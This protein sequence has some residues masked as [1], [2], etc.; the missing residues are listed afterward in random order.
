MKDLTLLFIAGGKSS[1]FGGE[2]KM[3]SK[4]GPN[5]ETLFEMSIGQMMN[6][7]HIVQIHVVVNKENKEKIMEE[8]KRVNQKHEI[9]KNITYNIQDVPEFRTKPWGTADAV[10]SAKGHVHTPFLL[11]NSDDLYDS[12]TFQ[13]IGQ[14]C[15][16]SKNY[17]IGFTLGSTLSGNQKA[18]RA[19]ISTNE[20]EKVIELQEKLNIE[21]DYYNKQQLENQYVSVN[22]LLLQPS[23]LSSMDRE[24]NEFKYQNKRDDSVEALLPNFLNSLMKQDILSMELFKTSGQWNGVTYKDDVQSVR[25]SFLSPRKEN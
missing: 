1:R 11:L 7:I 12:K 24:L 4:I 20:E 17:I 3:L 2:P 16:L 13:L 8:V 15:D 5:E 25:Q 18:N 21:R 22:L 23:I 9:C 19:F 6:H 14:V 10:S